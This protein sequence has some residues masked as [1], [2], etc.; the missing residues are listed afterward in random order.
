MMMSDSSKTRL[1]SG[2]IRLGEA[3]PVDVYHKS[4][5]LL[6]KKGHYVLSPEQRALLASAGES[7]R[8]EVDALLEQERERRELAERQNLRNR[9]AEA[10]QP[11]PLTEYE[12]LLRRSEGLLLHGLALPDLLAGLQAVA[13]GVQELAQRQPDGL[14][15]AMLLVPGREQVT[16]HALRVAVLLALAGK[17]MQLA[18]SEL[19][20]LC[21]AG[22][23]MNIAI[24][25]L[26]VRLGGQLDTLTEPEREAILAHPILSSAILREA[27]LSDELWHLLVQTHHE[28]ADGSGYPQGLQGDDVPALARLIALAD[29]LDEQISVLRVLPAQALAALFRKPDARF[30]PAQVSLLVKELGIYPPGSFVRLASG[31]IAVVT[32]RT[33]RANAPKVAALRK[34]NGPPYAEPLLRETR[35][36]A[37]RIIDAVPAGLALVKP[38]FLLRL[39]QR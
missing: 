31:E 29:V 39:W 14:I 4:G 27:G 30:D 9:I 28:V 21:G 11:N 1:P 19:E 33:E 10:R 34:E 38:G 36:S 3:L 2:F 24:T 6:L 35:Q 17:R 16:A 25:P 15:A 5:I 8:S 13:A 12:F 18:A 7:E 23:T 22:L 32:F 37:W 20:A 26:L